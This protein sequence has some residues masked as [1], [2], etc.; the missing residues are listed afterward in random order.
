M[1]KEKFK[2]F[3]RK[4][5]LKNA[6]S[7]DIDFSPFSVVLFQTYTLGEARFKD[8]ESVSFGAG[9]G[10]RR[11]FAGEKTNALAADKCFPIDGDAPPK[12][13]S[14]HVWT[15]FRKRLRSTDPLLIGI[16]TRA[17]LLPP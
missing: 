11:D 2:A 14:L 5:I 3:V 17:V 13:R 9:L 15:A 10:G 6:T 1:E 12:P 7:K 4:T 8:L 16:W